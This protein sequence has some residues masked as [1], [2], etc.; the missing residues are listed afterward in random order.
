[1]AGCPWKMIEFKETR[2]HVDIWMLKEIDA[3]K[4]KDT[5]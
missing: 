5:Q 1:M 2:C 4:Y 3:F